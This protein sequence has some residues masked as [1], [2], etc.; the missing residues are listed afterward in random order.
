MTVRYGINFT[1]LVNARII[2]HA[3][4]KISKLKKKVK[5]SNKF[6]NNDVRIL[7]NSIWLIKCWE[8]VIYTCVT[9]IKFY[10]WRDKAKFNINTK[11]LWLW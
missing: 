9:A 3:C 1:K 8:K 4:R 10:S 2:W 7:H 5:K 11:Y 6:Y